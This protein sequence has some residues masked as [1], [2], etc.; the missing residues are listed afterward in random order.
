[1]A[2]PCRQCDVAAAAEPPTV[3][4]LSRPMEVVQAILEAAQFGKQ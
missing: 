3:P 1:M 2:A 4:Q